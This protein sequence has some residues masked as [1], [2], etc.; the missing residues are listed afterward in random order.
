MDV[1]SFGYG[2]RVLGDCRQPRRLV[3]A[4]AALAAYA[5][6][7]PRAEL[8]RESFL[9][10]FRFGDDFR[11]YLSRTRSTKGFR[12][13]CWARWV[14]WDIDDAD[15][16]VALE[17]AR[18]LATAIGEL[19]QVAD[20]D[21]LV[22]FSGAKGAHIGVPTA[23]WTPEPGHDFHRV[24]KR[25]AES[26][27]E[28]A[29]V[30]IDC[31]IYDKVRCFRGPNSRHPK[32]GLHKRWLSVREIMGL[33]IDAILAMAAEPAPFDLP[34]PTY[35]SKPAATLWAECVG[36]V[37]HE[38]EA[39]AKRR[40]NGNG[41]AK[42]NRSTMDFIRDA[43]PVGDRHR[44]LYSAAANLAESGAP[45]GLCFALLDEPALDSGLPP[46]DVRRAMENG[47]Q[48]VNP[49]GAPAQDNAPEGGTL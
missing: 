13:P 21:V 43:A 6:C 19:L 39:V 3:D 26:V 30:Q 40:A 41:A 2:F 29:G 4:D 20:S 35:Q 32:T 5:A 15:L 10:A 33:N 23:L 17:S 38:A 36:Q 22:F 7:N 34:T 28:R 8:D 11:E 44:R 37:K 31:G 42:L 24:A 9:S 49:A 46:M 47:W 45:L 25:F 14:W 12:G 27:A 1:A 48:G 16:S 18:R